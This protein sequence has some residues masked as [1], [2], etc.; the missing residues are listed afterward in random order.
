[1]TPTSPQKFIIRGNF[2]W[3]APYTGNYTVECQGPAGGG[4]QGQSSSAGGGGG[5]SGSYALATFTATQG[6]AYILTVGGGGLNNTNSSGPTQFQTSSGTVICSAGGGSASSSSAGGAGG[7]ATIG[8]T[9]ISGNAGSATSGAVGGNG[10][11]AVGAYALSGGGQGG[12]GTVGSPGYSPGQG[13]GG[14]SWTSQSTSGGWGGD[15]MVV[16]S[17]ATPAPATTYFPPINAGNAHVFPFNGSGTSN[18]TTEADAVGG[19]TMSFPNG[20][21][22][23]GY[24]LRTNGIGNAVQFVSA[25]SQ[26]AVSAAVL[27]SQQNVTLPMTFQFMVI[28]SPAA[29]G[30]IQFHF[31]LLGSANLRLYTDLRS[32]S[33]NGNMLAVATGSGAGT[34]VF[35]DGKTRYFVTMVYHQIGFQLY[36]NGVL[37]TASIAAQSP[38]NLAGYKLTMGADCY[39]GTPGSFADFIISNVQFI[40]ETLTLDD[41][42]AYMNNVATLAAIG[43]PKN[44]LQHL[45]Q[46]F[47]QYT[48]NKYAWMSRTFAEPT[49][50]SAKNAGF[51]NG[52]PGAGLTVNGQ[53]PQWLMIYSTGNPEFIAYAICFGDPRVETNWTHFPLLGQ[54]YG[55][56]SGVVGLSSWWYDTINSVY[57]IQYGT[58]Y[59]GSKTMQFRTTDWVTFT[60]PAI[61]FNASTA[62]NTVVP[63]GQTASPFY[64]IL[65]MVPSG[66]KLESSTS[67]DQQIWNTSTTVLT[68]AQ[69]GGINCPDA[70]TFNGATY[71]VSSNSLQPIYVTKTYN[72]VDFLFSSVPI[73]DVSDAP[74]YLT[75]VSDMTIDTDTSGTFGLIIGAANSAGST[76]DPSGTNSGAFLVYAPV[77]PDVLFDGMPVATANSGGA[78]SVSTST[79]NSRLSGA[80]KAISTGNVKS[81]GSSVGIS[82][83]NSLIS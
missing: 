34:H 19:V 47:G 36:I 41:H 76:L 23:P 53:Q 46:L 80:S 48:Y 9:L 25:S 49:W 64:M 26:Y 39:S 51:P 29:S 61:A 70:V 59:S 27:P 69:V 14:G 68:T 15:G 78:A 56:V 17:F 62:Y 57:R 77:T 44:K 60:A 54:G 45:G 35:A 43:Q 18:T 30:N 67:S 38:F 6:A 52:W 28:Y 24:D 3:I 37:D 71:I 16:I 58:S 75:N 81:S 21:T 50:R 83:G 1:M 82:T 4:S 73:I 74:H 7:T 55:G 13:G 8:S 66:F 22:R 12:N 65:E 2:P 33:G 40:N 31:G 42:I 32:G 72:F 11:A 20:L 5:G 63:M 79:G 10:G